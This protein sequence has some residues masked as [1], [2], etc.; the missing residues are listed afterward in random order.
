MKHPINSS[1]ETHLI[2]GAKVLFIDSLN[3]DSSEKDFTHALL[4][5]P[6]NYLFNE[7]RKC[8]ASFVSVQVLECSGNWFDSVIF[9]STKAHAKK[10]YFSKLDEDRSYN[11]RINKNN[12][13]NLAK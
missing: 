7:E 6:K 5:L 9:F 4:E 2:N 12:H 8:F 3:F 1:F 13:K 11:Y 10:S